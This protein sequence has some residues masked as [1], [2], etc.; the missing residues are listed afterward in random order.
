MSNTNFIIVL[1]VNLEKTD[2]GSFIAAPTLRLAVLRRCLEG[3]D[4]SVPFWLAAG[5][6]KLRSIT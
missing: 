4:G 6:A 3:S 5:I 1:P 2:E